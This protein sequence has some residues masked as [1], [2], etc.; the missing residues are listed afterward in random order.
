MAERLPLWKK[1]MYALG[2]LGW[3][4]TS[5]AIGNALVYFYMPPEGV[6]FTQFIQKGIVFAG[7]TIVGLALGTS[8]LFDAITDPL[9]ATLSDRSKLKLGRRRGYLAIS[10]L[11]FALLSYRFYRHRVII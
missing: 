11:P 7:L 8:R 6:N 2:Q 4:L 1:W 5:F 9:V 10:V 3:S